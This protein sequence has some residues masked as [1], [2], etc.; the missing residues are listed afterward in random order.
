MMFFLT[1]ITKYVFVVNR[2]KFANLDLLPLQ[3]VE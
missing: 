2:L 1:L 3:I